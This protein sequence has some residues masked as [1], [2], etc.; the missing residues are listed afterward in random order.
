MASPQAACAGEP[1]TNHAR[2]I[3]TVGYEPV[4]Q[5]KSTSPT[6]APWPSQ[7]PRW[8]IS[9][10]P[11]RPTTA[12]SGNLTPTSGSSPRHESR[13]ATSP[14]GCSTSCPERASPRWVSTNFAG[15]RGCRSAPP[16][17]HPGVEK[18][19]VQVP[20]FED[21]SCR[22]GRDAANPP[23]LAHSPN[24][25]TPTPRLGLTAEEEH[26]FYADPAN[27]VPKGPSV[28]RRRNSVSRCRYVSP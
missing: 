15:R 8:P 2:L 4:P 27:Q 17:G 14:C 10:R 1:A 6:S 20:K 22:C 21:P 25:E 24:R 26:A 12:S 11:S 16:P 13:S 5:R 19:I 28:R 9:T 7:H 18:Q 3:R 23:G